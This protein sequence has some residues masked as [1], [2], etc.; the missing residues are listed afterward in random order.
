MKRLTAML[1]ILFLIAGVIP[2][3]IFAEE[4]YGETGTYLDFE[5][6]V[7]GKSGSYYKSVLQYKGEPASGEDPEGIRGKD[8]LLNVAPDAE[9]ASSLIW[10]QK[11][12]NDCIFGVSLYLDENATGVISAKGAG[13]VWGTTAITDIVRFDLGSIKFMGAKSANQVGT[14]ERAGWYDVRIWFDYS[15]HKLHIFLHLPDG[16]ELSGTYDINEEI[17]GNEYIIFNFA[18]DTQTYQL[19]ADDFLLY[20]IG[21]EEFAYQ[22]EFDESVST[23]LDIVFNR[24]VVAEAI[25]EG[26][27]VTESGKDV[28]FTVQPKYVGG[29]IKRIHLKFDEE[30]DIYG[31]YILTLSDKITSLAGETA[32]T[33]TKLFTVEPSISLLSDVSGG[34]LPTGTKVKLTA[35]IKKPRDAH[36]FYVINGEKTEIDG[37]LVCEIKRGV[38]EIYGE[39]ISGNDEVIA[40]S[41][42][43]TLIGKTWQTTSINTDDD[44]D[45]RSRPLAS[46]R[47]ESGYGTAEIVSGSGDCGNVL[48]MTT[49]TKASLA[50]YAVTQSI[51]DTSAGKSIV[52]EASFNFADFHAEKA[53]LQIKANRSNGATIFP[54]A[55]FVV[56]TDGELMVAYYQNNKAMRKSID[57]LELNHWYRLKAVYHLTSQTVD[58]YLDG[59]PVSLNQRL[60]D[61]NTMITKILYSN[62][63]TGVPAEADATTMFMDDVL[64]Y[65]TAPCV[66]YTSALQNGLQD[67]QALHASIE[68]SEEMQT[69]DLDKRIAVTDANGTTINYTGS[70]TDGRTYEMSFE[71]LVPNSVY[72]VTI[73]DVKS[74]VGADIDGDKVF[75]FKTDKKPFCI[76]EMNV[77]QSDNILYIDCTVRFDNESE[78]GGILDACVY[79]NDAMIASDAVRTV[80]ANSTEHK[81]QFEM[82]TASQMYD[83]ITVYLFDGAK[84]L[85]LIDSVTDK[86]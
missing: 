70:C 23:E 54:N 55:P 67:Y 84:T 78:C 37:E 19:R 25:A 73:G 28:S 24:D 30:P 12:L 49:K 58:C 16:E 26:I 59:L 85:C 22:T 21:E 27:S 65:E 52:Y 33:P 20:D 43:L 17:A 57:M 82:E 14:V 4:Q 76:K 45:V 31:E 80:K 47:A 81:Y 74:K 34:T 11:L 72:T 71:E 39:I 35:D 15:A 69:E 41:E 62:I 10:N 46:F 60:W 38:N 42:T 53:L 56:T 3:V 50:T 66:T 44:F 79:S 6:F 86:N 29:F 13:N 51:E 68:F 5:D 63:S 48:Q 32:C 83:S 40:T 1:M 77:R 8:I 2:Q 7:A 9:T 64:S 18:A 75:T 36:A 61:E